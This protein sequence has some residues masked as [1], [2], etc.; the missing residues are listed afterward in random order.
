[1]SDNFSTSENIN[2]LFEKLESF[3]QSKTV[4]GQPLNV[5]ETTIIPF[6]DISFGLGT[7]GGG[8]TDEKGIGGTGG[9][10]GTGAKISASAILVIKGDQ[11]ELLPIKKA[12]GLEKLIDMVPE[13]VEKVKDHK[14]CE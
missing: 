4:V 1:M 5:G 11:V 8:G 6:I 13:L 10:A 14:C 3:L 12:G 2:S 7:G 9:G